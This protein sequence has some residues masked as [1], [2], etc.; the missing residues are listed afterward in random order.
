MKVTANKN[1]KKKKGSKGAANKLYQQVI[2]MKQKT[3]EEE[4]IK[5]AIK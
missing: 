3:K 4:N 5:C 2:E 1:E